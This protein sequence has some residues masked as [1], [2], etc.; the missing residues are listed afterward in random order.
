ME[1]LSDTDAGK[2]S[3]KPTYPPGQWFFYEQV[4]Q[5]PFYVL[6]DPASGNLEV[7]R[8]QE[9]RYQLLSPQANSRYPIPPLQLELGVWQGYKEGRNGFW[10]RWWRSEG[11]LLLWGTE[12]LKQERQKLEQERQRA[13]RLAAY[14]RQQGV[15]PGAVL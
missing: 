15:D 9:G 10:L 11:E 4:V 7:Y 6:F 3:A 1:F 12:S 14:L 8:F 2:Y 5:V 13:E